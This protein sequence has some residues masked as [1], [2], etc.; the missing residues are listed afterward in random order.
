MNRPWN[1]DRNC[2][3]QAK[4]PANDERAVC[5]R[6]G[7]SSI[8]AVSTGFNR[9]RLNPLPYFATVPNNAVINI[10]GVATKVLALLGVHPTGGVRGVLYLAS[11]ILCCHV[12]NHMGGQTGC[13]RRSGQPEP[14]ES[15]GSPGS[16]GPLGPLGRL[17]L[18]QQPATVQQAASGEAQARLRQQRYHLHHPKSQQQGQKC[19]M[20]PSRL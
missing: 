17:A 1:S 3:F 9:P 7:T 5:P 13:Q 19:S 6:T 4:Q 2:I 14:P 10:A 15:T 8:K 16:L 18:R 11:L 20:H 12:P